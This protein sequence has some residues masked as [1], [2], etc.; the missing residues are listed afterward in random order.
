MPALA[1]KG[2]EVGVLQ[3]GGVAGDGEGDQGLV[4]HDCRPEQFLNKGPVAGLVGRLQP[5]QQHPVHVKV[6]QPGS[7]LGQSGTRNYV[8]RGVGHD[9]P[10]NRLPPGQGLWHCAEH[11]AADDGPAGGSLKVQGAVIDA[12][13]AH[14]Q[15]E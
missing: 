12:V 5:V 9:Q 4:L 2:V 13:A 6:V 14:R 15:V 3:Q 7:A 10:L 11:L 8:W 1:A